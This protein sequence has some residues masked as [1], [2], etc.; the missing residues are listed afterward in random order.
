MEDCDDKRYSG[1]RH[2][3]FKI[4]FEYYPKS[5]VSGASR[6][7]GKAVN[8]SLGG[9]YILTDTIVNSDAPI[10]LFFKTDGP[11]QH[12]KTFFVTNGTVIRSGAVEEESDEFKRKFGLEGGPGNCYCAVKFTSIQFELSSMLAELRQCL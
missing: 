10:A 5:A 7:R 6:G 12:D 9:V 1:R 2:A 11:E 4:D 8:I 3:D